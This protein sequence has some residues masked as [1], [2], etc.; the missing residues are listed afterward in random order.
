LGDERGW[1]DDLIVE[2]RLWFSAPCDYCECVVCVDALVVDGVDF[3]PGE[4]FQYLF[5]ALHVGGTFL[6]V[7]KGQGIVR[8]VGLFAGAG[9]NDQEPHETR[10]NGPATTCGQC[11]SD[12]ATE[13][14]RYYGRGRMAGRIFG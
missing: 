1:A 8:R 6:E 2:K 4:L 13:D 11:I 9:C 10:A 5:T 14:K 7:L 3:E 12:F